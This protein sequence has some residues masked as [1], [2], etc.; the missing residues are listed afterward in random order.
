MTATLT[1]AAAPVPDPHDASRVEAGPDL[2][3][4]FNEAGVLGPG[5]VH[6]AATLGRLSGENDP[7]V[8]LGVALAVRAPRFGHVCADL[9]TVRETVTADEDVLGDLERLPWPSA[10]VWPELVAR[11]AL[12]AVGP[13][14][15]GGRPLRLIAARLYLDRYWRYERRVV[16]ELLRRASPAARLD[17]TLL[18]KGL[19]RLFPPDPG[20]E[21]PDRQRMAA[22][23]AVLRRFAVIAGGPG[24]G[25]TTTVAR[26][27]ALAEE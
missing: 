9:A 25:K 19:E 23:A 15:A 2:L 26:V 6:V 7:Q 20:G 24:T 13:E 5:E 21:Q 4:G 10:A 8:L 14:A 3:R 1:G 22:A 18:Q 11:S 27:L 17:T 16:D 12:V